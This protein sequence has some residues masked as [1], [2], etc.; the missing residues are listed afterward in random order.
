APYAVEWEDVNP[1]ERREIAV[2]VV[3][4]F[5]REV[6]DAVVLDPYEVIQESEVASVLV[7]ASVQ[8]KSARFVKHLT[9]E[10]CSVLEDGVPQTLDLVQ[11]ESLGA[12]FALLVDS[13]GSM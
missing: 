2:A 12:V 9:Q 10:A 8:D 7:D 13:S 1:F 4:P 11:H 6:R 5:G 3:D